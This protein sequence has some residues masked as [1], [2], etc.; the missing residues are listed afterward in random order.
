MDTSPRISVHEF[1][2]PSQAQLPSRAT[3]SAEH[4][5]PKYVLC[6]DRWMS[7]KEV[8]AQMRKLRIVGSLRRC[9]TNCGRG[10]EVEKCLRPSSCLRAS[11]CGLRLA[12][13]DGS[14]EEVA[15]AQAIKASIEEAQR[16]HEKISITL[17]HLHILLDGHIATKTRSSGFVISPNLRPPNGTRMKTEMKVPNWNVLSLRRFED[18]MKD[19]NDISVPKEVQEMQPEK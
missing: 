1:H 9:S 17:I 19:I 3:A 6:V 18:S 5:T 2:E 7:G 16:A 11:I 14:T 15:Y 10:A 4:F 13:E 12:Q 8:L